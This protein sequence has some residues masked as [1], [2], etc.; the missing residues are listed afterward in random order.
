MG[1]LNK[2]IKDLYVLVESATRDPHYH[3][4]GG[5][6]G[7]LSSKLN[8]SFTDL[9]GQVARSFLDALS[10]AVLSISRKHKNF[11]YS[12]QQG[13]VNYPIGQ[14][15]RSMRNSLI[16]RKHNDTWYSCDLSDS[17]CK[18]S[19]LGVVQDV[20]D[21][22]FVVFVK[23][24][25]D[26]LLSDVSKLDRFGPDD[27]AEK[28]MLNLY[29]EFSRVFSLVSDAICDSLDSSACFEADDAQIAFETFFGD[30]GF[31]EDVLSLCF[32]EIDDVFTNAEIVDLLFGGFYIRS[33]NELDV[34]IGNLEHSM[35][36]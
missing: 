13:S 32:D 4:F 36:F 1:N 15:A 8:G 21:G 12:S 2:A 26:N 30:D 6:P 20:V 14:Y 22:T 31:C 28:V 16:G 19:V 17:S 29:S 27:V 35:W 7:S 9:G 23:H 11:T 18:K 3:E 34:A 33:P 24:S 5:R 25:V 10:D